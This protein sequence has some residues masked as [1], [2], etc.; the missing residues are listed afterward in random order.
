MAINLSGHA[1]IDQQ[2]ELLENTVGQLALFCSE[3]KN[4]PDATCDGCNAFKQKRC[5]F[6]LASIASELT[7]FLAGH[8]AYEE[9]MMELLPCTPICQEHVKAHK[10]AHQGIAKHL[11]RLSLQVATENPRDVSTL[12]RRIVGDWLGDH[13]TSFDTRLVRLGKFNSTK[14]DF[15]SELVS[16]LDEYVFPS[17]PTISK[18]S[19]KV[20]VALQEKK[21][22][23]RERFES[24]S[25]A[26]RQ[27]FWLVAGG[28]TN[29]EIGN[30]LTVSINT[31]KTHRAAIFH[32]MDVKSALELVKKVDVLR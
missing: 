21:L 7:D 26:Q 31:V 17:R 19:L 30:I 18:A 2:H 6:V 4:N 16:M 14:T 23:T 27:V 28:K 10:S 22:E 32:K 12:M 9:K 13:S 20:S 8:A 1:E 25:P 11:K 29:R 3:D 24:L 15:D 5:S